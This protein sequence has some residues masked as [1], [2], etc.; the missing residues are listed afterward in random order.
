MIF[1]SLSSLLLSWRFAGALMATLL[2]FGCRAGEPPA[3]VDE[4]PGPADSARREV[5]DETP[6]SQTQPAMAVDAQGG[7]PGPAGA[8]D[9]NAVAKTGAES[10]GEANA[11][12][13]NAVAD[14]AVAA[15]AKAN[16]G[17]GGQPP[18][19]ELLATLVIPPPWLDEV[20]IEYDTSHPWKDARLEI[21][22]LLSLGQTE[23]HRQALKLTW[24]YRQQGDIGDGHEYPT[25]TFL[26]GEPLW[27][28][29]A[30]EEFLAQPH[31]HTPIHTHLSLASLYAQHGEFD[32]ALA[33]LEVALDG[34]P[35]PPWDVMRKADLLDAL[36]D[37][38]AAWGRTDEA[39]RSWA[40]AAALYPKAKPP[41][42][43][44][45]LPRRAAQV[46]SKLDLLAVRSLAAA[47]LRD[48]QY[49]DKALGYAGD[50]DVTL[51]V[52]DGKLADIRLRHE[53]KID[54]NACVLIPRRILD[55]QSLQVDGISGATV[56]TRAIVHGVL[57]CLRQAGLE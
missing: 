53:E 30:H 50:I 48:G 40:D 41:Y 44:H 18:L 24:L 33:T 37:L 39:Q 20:Q 11:A 54:Q 16:A 10:A 8:G 25:Y 12:A 55:A 47:T 14:N 2:W 32:K 28:I 6:G 35:P 7:T 19:Q 23:T 31:E 57:G 34:L 29:R 15:A 42:G 1:R 26:G 56:T 9:V 49:Q 13:D 22:R 38:Y 36:G 52:Q 46:Q 51:V 43:G 27:S 4:A 3:T 21:R 17:A 45:L 5:V